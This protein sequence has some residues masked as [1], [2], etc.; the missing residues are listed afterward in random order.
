MQKFNV[1]RLMQDNSVRVLFEN[2]S[3]EMIEDL[4]YTLKSCGIY[5]SCKEEILIEPIGQEV[6][7][8]L[9]DI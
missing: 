4:V 6:I 5:G 3:R 8:M 7:F 1:L 2:T 9:G